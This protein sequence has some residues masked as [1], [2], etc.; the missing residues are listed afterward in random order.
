MLCFQNCTFLNKRYRSTKFSKTTNIHP[1]EFRFT[2]QVNNTTL[3]VHTSDTPPIRSSVWQTTDVIGLT[4]FTKFPPRTSVP[5][6]NNH[7]EMQLVTPFH[8]FPLATPKDY[9]SIMIHIS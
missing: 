4:Y 8:S 3:T 5:G 9:L 6:N 7:T 2:P 1:L